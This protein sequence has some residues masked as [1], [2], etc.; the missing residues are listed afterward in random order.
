M[1]IECTNSRNNFCLKLLLQNLCE[2][3][4]RIVL[5]IF[6]C[7]LKNALWH[8]VSKCTELEWRH[9]SR[10][11]LVLLWIIKAFFTGSTPHGATFALDCG[12]KIGVHTL[13]GVLFKV[14]KKE[15]K[16]LN[17]FCLNHST[18][19]IKTLKLVKLVW[20]LQIE[21]KFS[22]PQFLHIIFLKDTI[23]WGNFGIRGNFRP[24]RRL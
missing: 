8:R 5:H 17:T 13:V 7:F 23:M 24:T 19:Y 16:I 3:H 21:I 12:K 6:G 9:D 22:W 2:P 15:R 18:T 1:K 10:V 14:T 20:K 11:P 4:L